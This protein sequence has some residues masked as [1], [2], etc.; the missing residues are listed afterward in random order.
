MSI[1]SQATQ[2]FIWRFSAFNFV[3]L[4]LL[5]CWLGQQNQP[6]ALPEPHLP[7]DA[8]LQCVSYSPYY[9]N[10]QTP[11]NI[12]THIS[13]Q[14]IDHDLATLSKQFACVRI[15]S[16]GQGLDYVPEA[17]SKLGMKVY[18]GAWIGWVKKLNERELNLAI[19]VANKYPD[20]VKALI[21]GN[22]VLLRGEQTESAMKAYIYRAK[23]A[24]KVAVTYADVWEFWRKHPSLEDSVDFVT[25]H[26]LPYWEDN[27]QPIDHALDHTKKVMDLIAQTFKKPILIGETGW[28]SAGRQRE[29]AEPS[30]INQARYIRGFL[31]L[32]DEQHWNYNLIEAFDQP[33]KRNLEGTAGGY[34]GMFKV[35][36][37]P[38]FSFSG[39]L[40]ERDDASLAIYAGC[41]GALLFLAYS[42]LFKLGTTK[43]HISMAL[44]GALVGVNVLLQAEYLAI[45][46]RTP[47]E[48]LAL[49][50][51]AL[52]GFV[53]LLSLPAFVFKG[54]PI[55]KK[56]LSI[57]STLFLLAA[58]SLNYLLL[59]DGRYRDFAIALYALP[60]LQLS[61]GLFIF[62]QSIKPTFS[63][64]RWLGILLVVSAM[65]C[66][67][68]EPSNHLAMIWLVISTLIAWA[69]WP[70][71]RSTTI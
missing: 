59:V 4:L 14:Q 24:T 21:V 36:M 67:Y 43:H 56:L 30:L 20:T 44:F 53:S 68:K 26:I 38:K 42:L 65:V 10:G 17:A 64:Y 33:W 23:T 9:K 5:A 37:T 7:V 55:A 62:K 63:A 11:L 40:A 39:N 70:A 22:E 1:L 41:L 28:P 35:D 69:N 60:A 27:P 71:K 32:A 31:M 8:K 3:L 18:L 2:Q 66:L 6:I 13:H 12:Q 46:C 25:V 15:Y 50:G 51:L 47:Q 45:A 19:A 34:W 52:L 61:L 49:G 54:Y 48:W 29:G 16:V 58:L 57:S